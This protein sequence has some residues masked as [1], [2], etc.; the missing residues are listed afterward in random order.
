[1][2]FS[3]SNFL[4]LGGNQNQ[5]QDTKKRK[6]NSGSL[7]KK[8]PERIKMEMDVLIRAVEGALDPIN[9]DRIDLLTMYENTWKDSQ[10][11]SEREKA[12]AYL[13]TEPF[14]VKTGGKE[15]KDKT[16]FFN[17]P[18]FTK[19]LVYDLWEEFWGYTLLEFQDMDENGE[20]KDVIIFPRKYVRP[21]EKIIT[22]DPYARTEGVS[23]DIK[24]EDFFLLELGDK[25][26][27]GK[28][29][30][31]TKE[32]IWKNFAR[33]DWSEYNERYG[34][35]LLD[36][37]T[38]TSDTEELDKRVEM[39]ANFGTNCYV[40]RDTS[41]QINMISTAS[42]SSAENYKD[43]AV[44]C[45]EQIS[46]LFNG[47]TGTSQ[48]KSFVGAAE[49]H[50]RVLDRFTEARLVRI[51]NNINYRLIPF[52]RYHGY[53]LAEDDRFVFRLLEEQRDN[54]GMPK[55]T[56]GSPVKQPDKPNEGDDDNNNDD[57][58]N[59]KGVLGFFA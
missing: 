34:K 15:N 39:A 21:F 49:V 19:Y 24:P 44:F 55:V 46:K 18:W 8:Q 33:S 11:I 12:D 38:D 20:F 32:V 4:G 56:P 16:K 40:V 17:R 47:Q 31:C 28:L 35:P 57:G 2:K 29:E 14:Y 43:M 45:D 3:I 37:A 7:I 25:E 6:R 59:N 5:S 27:L 26:L 54:A 41:D 13:L 36:F 10:V 53:P 51:E 52:L 50:E 1:M 23:Y 58:T 9:N 48:E 22:P 42:R 30:T